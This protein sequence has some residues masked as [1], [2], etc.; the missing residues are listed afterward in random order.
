MCF[1]SLDV[2]KIL[3]KNIVLNISIRKINDV[4]YDSITLMA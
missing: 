3:C 1:K 2:K 4:A